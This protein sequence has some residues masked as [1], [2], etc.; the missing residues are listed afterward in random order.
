[1]LTRQILVLADHAYNGAGATFRTPYYH[2]SE[3]PPHYQQF[4]RHAWRLLLRRPAAAVDRCRRS[5]A[6]R[7]SAY[8]QK[9]EL[10]DEQ[11]AFLPSSPPQLDS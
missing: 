7:H 10:F 3:Q 6:D 2:H 4:V 8:L 5:P 9:H 11:P 1:C